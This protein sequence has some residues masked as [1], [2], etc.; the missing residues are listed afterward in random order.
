MSC[1]P[2]IGRREQHLSADPACTLFQKFSFIS[3]SKIF[4]LV[5]EVMHSQFSD[6]MTFYQTQRVFSSQINVI[7]GIECEMEMDN[8][9]I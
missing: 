1:L 4:V 9:D 5:L 7:I 8:V 6:Y 2:S 3:V